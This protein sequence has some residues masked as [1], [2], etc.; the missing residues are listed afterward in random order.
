[1]QSVLCDGVMRTEYYG[2]MWNAILVLLTTV[3][4][5]IL[6]AMQFESSHL[7]KLEA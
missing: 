5:D 3:T 4:L 6:Y 2:A 7:V 1:M